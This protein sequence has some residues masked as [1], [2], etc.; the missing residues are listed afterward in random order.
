MDLIGRL[1]DFCISSYN[2]MA[3]VLAD[4]GKRRAHTHAVSRR[5]KLTIYALVQSTNLENEFFFLF[6]F[7]DN[8]IG[9]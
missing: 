5:L 4:W 8:P 9:I 6:I 1:F 7:W 3:A 2:K